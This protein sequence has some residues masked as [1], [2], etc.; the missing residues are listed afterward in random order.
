GVSVNRRVACIGQK[1][2]AYPT[3]SPCVIVP[4]LTLAPRLVDFA[5][6][7]ARG[8]ELKNYVVTKFK[9]DVGLLEGDPNFEEMNADSMTRLEILLHADDT[10]GSHVLD[11]IED[12][13][14]TGQPP[15]R[16]SELAALIPLCMVPV[17]VLKEQ[18][19]TQAQQTHD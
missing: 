5:E 17:R 8:S 6:T 7:F 16:L 19:N 4:W 14:L 15:E 9:L 13:L 11:Y 18:R 10:Y 3:H 1:I 2:R 12:G